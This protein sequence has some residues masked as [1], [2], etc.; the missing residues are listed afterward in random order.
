MKYIISFLSFICLVNCSTNSVDNKN[1]NF[2]L[3]IDVNETINLNFPQFS[4]L[5]SI[6]VPVHIPNIGGQDGIIVNNT[7]ARYVAFD[8]TDPNHAPSSCSFLTVNG[9]I[10][11]CNCDDGNT[12]SLLDGIPVG[13]TGTQCPLR[14]YVVQRSGDNL[15]IFN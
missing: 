15:S 8:A 4:Q 11:E 6:N 10:A 5:K 14:G 13:N 9:I 7:G 12:Y 1:C 3:D 2:L